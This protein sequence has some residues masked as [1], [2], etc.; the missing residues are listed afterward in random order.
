MPSGFDPVYL[1]ALPA[2]HGFYERLGWRL[3]EAG[4]T[5]FG[6]AVFRSP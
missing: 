5:E 2:K 3:V 1:C 4:V 6:L